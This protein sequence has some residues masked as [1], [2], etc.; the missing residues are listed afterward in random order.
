LKTLAAASS[1][2][3]GDTE[4]TLYQAEKSKKIS[5]IKSQH[6]ETDVPLPKLAQSY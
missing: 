4:L 6:R 5:I 2:R 3:R 1:L